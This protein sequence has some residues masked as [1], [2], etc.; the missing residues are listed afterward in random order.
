MSDPIPG[1][2][3]L[4]RVFVIRFV[5]AFFPCHGAQLSPSTHT[6]VHYL[7]QR[8]GSKSLRKYS[9]HVKHRSKNLDHH[10]P[11]RSVCNVQCRCQCDGAPFKMTTFYSCVSIYPVPLLPLSP[12]TAQRISES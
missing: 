7:Q 3:Q 12:C 11:M 8:C 10:Q 1:K 4:A 6:F 5:L 9:C 2:P